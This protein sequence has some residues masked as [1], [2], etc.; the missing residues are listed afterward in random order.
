MKTTRRETWEARFDMH[1]HST[2]SDGSDTPEEILDLAEEKWLELITLLD[3]DRVVTEEFIA[4]A[5]KR[6]IETLYSSEL[7]IWLY[8]EGKSMHFWYYSTSVSEKVEEILEKTRTWS[9]RMLEVQIQKLSD[10]WFDITSKDFDMF[11]AWKWR[12]I[13]GWNKFWIVECLFQ[14]VQNVEIAE[15][16]L[17]RKTNIE[18]FFLSCLKAWGEKNAMF[19]VKIDDYEP[20]VEVISE[21]SAFNDTLIS[22]AHPNFT[23]KWWI[24]EFEE[25]APKLIELWVGAIEINSKATPEWIEAIN[26]MCEKYGLLRTMW[27]DNHKVWYTDNKHG[28]FWELNPHVSWDERRKILDDFKNYFKEL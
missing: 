25:K 19:N 11:L 21:I 24:E 14:K 23:F 4:S 10:L 22:I 17:W 1:F 28:D 8:E 20:S 6:W 7:S 15:K 2:R 12:D 13:N 26:E 27:S 18:D 16:I 5:R 3:H 9:A